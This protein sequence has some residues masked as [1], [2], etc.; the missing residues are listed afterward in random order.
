MAGGALFVFVS[1]L[2]LEEYRKA[3]MTDPVSV[4][5]LEVLLSIL[6]CGAPGAMAV[7]CLVAGALFFGGGVLLLIKVLVQ[8]LP[9][10]W[11]LVRL[12]LGF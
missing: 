1:L 7:I 4:M 9:F 5:S 12:S 8:G 11:H 10:L 2:L 6:R 3:F